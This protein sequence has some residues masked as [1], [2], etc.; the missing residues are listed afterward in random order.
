LEAK[1]NDALATYVALHDD[2]VGFVADAPVSGT[3]ME[4][5]LYTSEH[6]STW[7][8]Q[9]RTFQA[10]LDRNMPT[11]VDLRNRSGAK[12]DRARAL[13]IGVFANLGVADNLLFNGVTDLTATCNAE[14][15]RLQLRA[16]DEAAHTARLTLD[17]KLTMDSEAIVTGEPD[18]IVNLDES[19]KCND[20]SSGGG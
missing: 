12:A 14:A 18:Y 4:M 7:F 19:N 9:E 17:G 5:T 10:S 11:V 16:A 1:A 13:I 2:A 20:D 6:V 15:A 3:S 8:D